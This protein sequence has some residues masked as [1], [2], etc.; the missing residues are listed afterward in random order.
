MLYSL[1]DSQLSLRKGANF[2]TKLELYLHCVMEINFGKTGD[3]SGR[4]VPDSREGRVQGA[5]KAWQEREHLGV[6]GRG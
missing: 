5:E 1:C 6:K 4:H 2:C 3:A